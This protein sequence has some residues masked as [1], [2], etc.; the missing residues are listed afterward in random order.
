MNERVD[1]ESIVP[2][3]ETKQDSSDPSSWYWVDRSIWTDRM[4]A[5][6]VNGVKGNRNGQE[7]GGAV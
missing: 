6:L 1:K 7:E 5:A 2:Q 4:L 3:Q